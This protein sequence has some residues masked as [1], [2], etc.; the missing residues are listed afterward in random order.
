LLE[1]LQAKGVEAKIHYPIPVHLQKASE[2]LGYNEGDL[3]FTEADAKEIITLP[4][5]Q[6][7]HDYEIQYTIEQIRA[8]YLR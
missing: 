6:H 3:P 8:F 4:A 5:H 2:S 7:L 1:Y